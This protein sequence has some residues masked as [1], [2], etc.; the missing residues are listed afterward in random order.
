MAAYTLSE[1]QEMLRLWKE[2]VRQLASG[3]AKEYRIGTREYKAIDL[4]EITGRIAY[5]ESQVAQLS[6]TARS[7]RVVR[8]VPRDL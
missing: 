4:P 6:G 1:A 8:V 7:T 5:F 3:Q 2:C